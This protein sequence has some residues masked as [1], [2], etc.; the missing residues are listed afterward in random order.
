MWE[1][2]AGEGGIVE[3]GRRDKVVGFVDEVVCFVDVRT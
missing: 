2:G 1:E 3:G